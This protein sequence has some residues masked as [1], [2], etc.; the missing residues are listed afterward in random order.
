M[1]Q[2]IIGSTATGDSITANATGLAG[3][4]RGLKDVFKEDVSSALENINNPDK[5]LTDIF[6]NRVKTP[7]VQVYNKR[8]FTSDNLN[9]LK[10]SAKTFF[11]KL[12]SAY[13][14][15]NLVTSTF[16]PFDMSLEIDGLSGFTVFN[17]IRVNEEV[18]PVSYQN[19]GTSLMLSAMDQ[20]IDDSGW[21]TSLSCITFS[22]PGLTLGEGASMFSTTAAVEEFCN[23]NFGDT[24]DKLQEKASATCKG[25]QYT[26]IKFYDPANELRGGADV[27]MTA[28][29]KEAH[30]LGIT[31]SYLIG[32]LFISIEPEGSFQHKAE[33]HIARQDTFR[34]SFGPANF[35]D[36]YKNTFMWAWGGLL[37]K[38]KGY[39]F[40]YR[41]GPKMTIDGVTYEN[42]KSEEA[43]RAYFHKIWLPFLQRIWEE[44]K[45]KSGYDRWKRCEAIW[46]NTNYGVRGSAAL[47]DVYGEDKGGYN[48]DWKW[49]DA[50]TPVGQ[51]WLMD[52]NNGGYKYRGLGL[53]QF[54]GPSA[55]I[56]MDKLL[57]NAGVIS[58]PICEDN[59]YLFVYDPVNPRKYS[60]TFMYPDTYF[61]SLPNNPL[62]KIN[63]GYTRQDVLIKGTMYKQLDKILSSGNFNARIRN[64]QIRHNLDTSSNP[65]PELTQNVLDQLNCIDEAWLGTC[66]GIFVVTGTGSTAS[67]K[68]SKYTDKKADFEKHGYYMQYLKND[69]NLYIND[70][71]Q[72]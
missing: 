26:G 39:G 6:Q 56:K 33:K 8:V 17:A 34:L 61:E 62:L 5:D 31:N 52:D 38:G 41:K 54:T 60:D 69:P 36:P 12:L 18:L 68:F 45:N 1:N 72:I 71:K 25:K 40:L 67:K 64:G 7:Y 23:A 44:D 63:P 4:N 29:Y 48:M 53:T 58:G 42:F 55:F 20:Q 66:L 11:R 30:N 43:R 70:I 49:W 13:S 9:A 10:E 3:Y 46:G 59:P 22:D 35:D 65:R 2:I 51:A 57:I 37:P 14:N 16:L 47:E 21:K 27:N 32:G 28:V 50:S 19:Q 15:R 24:S